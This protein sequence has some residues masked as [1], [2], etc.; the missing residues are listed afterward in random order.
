M[1]RIVG[2]NGEFQVGEYFGQEQELC[3]T[4][5]NLLRFEEMSFDG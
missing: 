2:G 3:V 4:S 1:S 5:A